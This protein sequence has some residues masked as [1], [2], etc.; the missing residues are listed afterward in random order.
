MN[1]L[2]ISLSFVLISTISFAQISK[3]STPPSFENRLSTDV[4]TI[5][6][7][8]PS[9]SE[10]EKIINE[11]DKNGSFYKFG[12]IIESDISPQTHGKWEELENGNRVWRLNVRI[13]GAKALGLYYDSFWIPS[14][15]EFFV[16]NHDKSQILGAYTSS[17]NKSHG[18][19]SNELI[20]GEF[21]T[22]EYHQKGNSM[23][24]IHINE[25]SYCFRGVNNVF[26]KD[27][28]DFGSS[29]DCQVNSDCHPE[30]QIWRNE[31]RSACR[32]NVRVGNTAGWC[33]GA[34]INNTAEN[35][36]PYVLTAD[37]CA[38]GTNS[39]ATASDMS[40]WIFYFLY[41]SD[42][43]E[44]PNSNPNS[45]SYAGCDLISS[46]GTGNI[47]STS[48][49][50]LIEL[51]D[52]LNPTHG[53]YLSG[54]NKNNSAS[55]TGVSI[56]HPS[57]DIQKISTY[58][59][60][61]TTSGWNGGGSTHWRVKW[62]E[63]TNGHG[64]TEGGSSGSPLY[65]SQKQIIGDLSG[66]SSYCNFTNGRDLYGK[67]SYS[68]DQNGNSNNRKLKPWLDPTNSGVSS[69]NGLLC[70]A[71]ADF[72]ATHYHINPGG[73]TTFSYDGTATPNEYAWTFFGGNPVTTSETSPTVTYAN[74]GY[75][76]VK[77]K[78]T[79]ENNIEYTELKT[80]YV[81]VDANGSNNSINELDNLNFNIF[82]NPSNGILH[83]TKDKIEKS[84]ISILNV[85][86]QEVYQTEFN[87][88]T[89]SIDLSSFE[90][91]AYLIKLNIAN[92]V[93]TKQFILNK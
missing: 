65:N 8:K 84:T 63:T 74:D 14:G 78:V 36:T 75:Y 26:K 61:P 6:L 47:N 22:L 32:I 10:I 43:C 87:N 4:P 51:E 42:F 16:Y 40:Q 44:D 90:N 58:T 35:C 62:A 85:L 45:T 69:M 56:H 33:S 17:N 89:T 38:W 34:L 41:M 71:Y 64:V 5:D 9:N 76:N 59:V 93:L 66:G 72:T 39:Y 27:I 52:A 73:E 19:F 46:S 20:E 88:Q 24:I 54:W 49:F 50:Y 57:G 23:P 67:L 80:Q 18:L 53:L 68:W 2:I 82:P 91:G 37:H 15:G 25:I 48:D 86:G 21:L 60:T 3:E 1:K 28:N 12:L 83:L 11:E 55:N 29:D 77:L 92:S 13:E 79:D 7:L 70:G 30:G 81:K 31:K